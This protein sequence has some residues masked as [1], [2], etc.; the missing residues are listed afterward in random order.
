MQVSPYWILPRNAIFGQRIIYDVRLEVLTTKV[1][2]NQIFLDVTLSRLVNSCPIF[3]GPQ[4]H[5]EQTL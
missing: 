4:C 5:Y 3:E 2:Y 1:L